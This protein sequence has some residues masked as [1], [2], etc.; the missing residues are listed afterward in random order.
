MNNKKVANKLECGLCDGTEIETYFVNHDFDY[1]TGKSAV[2]LTARIPIRNCKSCEL[3]FIDWEGEDILH[4]TV[5]YHLGV[6][7]PRDIQEIRKGMKMSRSEFGELTGFG[8]A[9]I[10]RWENGSYIQSRA[11][12]KH[13]RLIKN[14]ISDLGTDYYFK[15]MQKSPRNNT[16]LMK[17]EKRFRTLGGDIPRY[18]KA[19]ASFTL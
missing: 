7:T 18:T 4:D 13:L 12:D 3:E 5:C 14:I 8:E 15:T 11:N 9:S 1:G 17:L 19:Q 10:S 16:I 6:L 2:K